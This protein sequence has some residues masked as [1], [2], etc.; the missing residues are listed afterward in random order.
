MRIED[1]SAFNAVR[2]TGMAKLLPPHP[3]IAIGH[4]IDQASRHS[5]KGNK[6]QEGMLNRV[7]AVVHAYDPCLSSSTHAQGILPM[8]IEL[9]SPDGTVLDTL[10]SESLVL[11]CVGG[12]S[13]FDGRRQEG[14]FST[15]RQCRPTTGGE[16]VSYFATPF[17]TGEVCL[18]RRVCP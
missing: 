5:A 8:Q 9:V 17:F 2:E 10:R 14:G 6:L 16:V 11:T 18:V 3:R 12:S 1:L 15:P 4:S 7:S 13:E